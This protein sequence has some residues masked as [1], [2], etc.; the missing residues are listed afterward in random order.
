MNKDLTVEFFR[1]DLSDEELGH[2]TEVLSSEGEALRFA[3]WA[4]AFH[5]SLGAM[6][7]LILLLKLAL[8]GLGKGAGGGASASGL[9]SG[10]AGKAVV[11]KAVAI[12]LGTSVAVGTSVVA[13]KAMK[14]PKAPP[15]PLVATAA[16]QKPAVP[17]AK[18]A[19]ARRGKQLV[20][21][22]ELKEPASVQMVVKNAD[23]RQVS[24][25]GTQALA[26][27][28]NRVVWN[29][30]AMDGSALPPGRYE[31]VTRWNGKELSRWVELRPGKD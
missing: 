17:R 29:G 7:A 25:L 2:L 24:S 12:A 8:N 27:G 18:P 31:I 4:R 28:M 19:A 26:A 23:G 11:V 1:R 14:A 9:G 30:R 15:V 16:P 6:A 13:Y 21:R 20:I 5:R 3:E 10:L 22:L